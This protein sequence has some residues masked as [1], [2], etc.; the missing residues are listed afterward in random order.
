MK[1]MGDNLTKLFI[2][3]IGAGIGSIITWKFVEAKYKKIADEEIASVKEVYS[4]DKT[5]NNE[6]VEKEE[7]KVDEMETIVKDYKSDSATE[8]ETLKPYV[9]DPEGFGEIENYEK[10]GLTYYADGYLTDEDDELVNDVEGKIGWANLNSFG[11][12]EDDAVH[13]RNDILMTDYEILKD[14]RLY[15]EIKED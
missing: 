12:Y 13:I 8:I 9:I 5:E 1:N 10:V 7:E 3:S 11:E 6:E 14:E 2:F 15:K 4:R